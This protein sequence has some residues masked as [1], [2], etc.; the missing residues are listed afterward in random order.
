MATSFSLGG[1]EHEQ[2]VVTVH[3]YERSLTGEYSDDNWLSVAVEVSAG[4]FSGNFSAAFVTEDFVR[5][6][7]SL[8][9]LYE[10]LKGE[11]E[12]FTLEEQLSLKLVGNGRGDIQV[13]GIAVDRAGDG[14]TL[15]FSLALDQT[16]LAATL[17]GLNA[18]VS[19]FPVR[20]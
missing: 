15:H 4:A 8:Q 19:E 18:I 5:F 7:L 10:S 14:N 16:H 1:S 11:S 9:Q 13:L 2:V 12:F 6:R 20:A 3:G 17:G